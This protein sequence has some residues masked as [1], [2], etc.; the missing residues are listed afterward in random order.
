MKHA[1]VAVLNE[2]HELNEAVAE[3]RTRA[4]QMQNRLD[5]FESMLQSL[6]VVIWRT[7]KQL[8]LRGA[9]GMLAAEP[10][11]NRPIHELYRALFDVRDEEQDP[12]AAHRDAV[13]G[14]G[15]TLCVNDSRG[16][17]A[18]I[19]EPKRNALGDIVGTVGISIE[20]GRC[21]EFRE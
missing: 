13:R 18:M 15:V 9:H 12:L 8:R 4:R 2:L 7:D 21:A 5:E 19:V 20:L 14:R 3:H 10:Y 1:N 17:Y 11:I 6:G 16:S